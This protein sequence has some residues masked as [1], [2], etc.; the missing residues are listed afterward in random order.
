MISKHL[1][2]VWALALLALPLVAQEP[3]WPQFRGPGGQGHSSAVGVPTA[4]SENENIVWKAPLP[5]RGWSSPVIAGNQIWLTSAIET[6]LT[7]AEKAERLKGNTGNQ[8]LTVSGPLSLRAICV[9][10]NSGAIVHNVEL[11]IESRPQPAHSMNSFASPTP[12]LEGGRLYCHFGA[13]GSACV[14][15]TTGKVLWTNRELVINHENGPGSSPVLW[16]DFLIFH[17]DG[18]D[19]QFIVALDK[20][21]GRVAWKTP[22]TGKMNDNPQLKKAYGTPLIVDV[23]G[24]PQ[25]FSPAADWLYGYDPATGRELWKMPYEMLGFSIVPRPVVGHGM[26]YMSTSFMQPQLLAVKYDGG[27]PTI[28]WRYAKQAPTM[29]SPLLVGERLYMVSERGVATCLNALTGELVWT[30]RLKGNFAASP[31]Y[32][33]GKIHCCNRDGETIVLKPGDKYELL[34]LNKLDGQILA[35]PAAVKDALY[36]RTDQALY[37]IEY[38]KR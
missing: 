4:W 9:A 28:A 17:C 34:A 26:L 29:P 32:A 37:R 14:D 20:N 30:E 18:S 11:L 5:G 22:R 10:R 24:Q 21:T 33:D 31:L 25:L 1:P 12:V 23:A 15:T 8:P 3:E 6:P 7:E 13:Y 16:K 35:S 2:C 36:L 27:E 19:Q 38:L